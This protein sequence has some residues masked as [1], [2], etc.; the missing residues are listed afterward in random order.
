MGKWEIED[1]GRVREGEGGGGKK[2][3]IQSVTVRTIYS[4]ELLLRM[5]LLCRWL[6]R[7]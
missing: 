2:R 1:G 5:L 4:C 7:Q 6:P 3:E